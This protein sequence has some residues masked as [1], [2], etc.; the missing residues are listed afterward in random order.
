MPTK[1]QE[2][3]QTT[4]IFKGLSDHSLCLLSEISRDYSFP[5]GSL[6]FS[7]GDLCPGLY[8]VYEGVVRVFKV[9]PSGKEHILHFAEK[10]MTF[11]EVAVMGQFDCPAN[12]E[13]LENSRCL[14]L[15]AD[16]F[17]NLLK[18]NH[19]LCFEFVSGMAFWVRELVGLLENIVLRD[20][21]S[22]L[23]AF[24]L[25]S[26]GDTANCVRL[27]SILKKDFASHLNLTSET[28]SRTLRRLTQQGY[29]ETPNPQ[30]IIILNRQALRDLAEGLSEI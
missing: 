18:T 17:R 30:T 20:A 25:R 12:A 10:G 21:A 19:E 14:L 24:M 3:L 11:A 8:V 2:I 1:T 22:R 15:P 26:D 9:A 5:K 23:A 16:A 4:N 7:E 6:I 29:I 28:V 27:S 13:A